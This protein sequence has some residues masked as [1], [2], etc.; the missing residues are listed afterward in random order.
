MCIDCL[1]FLVGVIN[2]Q[3]SLMLYDE[4]DFIKIDDE[5]EDIDKLLQD[6][7]VLQDLNKFEIIDLLEKQKKVNKVFISIVVKDVF[8]SK[9]FVSREIK[10]K[11]FEGSY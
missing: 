3:V 6:L 11:I 8:F 5:T 9:L 7:E 4:I 1:F 2:D 10:N